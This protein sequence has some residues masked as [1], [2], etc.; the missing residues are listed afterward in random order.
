MTTAVKQAA[1]KRL[2]GL[3]RDLAGGMM[4]QMFFWGRDVVHPSGNLL[5]AQGFERHAAGGKSGTSCYRCRW[6]DGSIELL[7]AS[8]A[9]YPDGGGSGFI[10]IR[11]LG[12]CYRWLGN[13]PP[14]P[15]EWPVS[16]L[17][18]GDGRLVREQALPFIDWW[19]DSERRV[20][21][22]QGPGYRLNCYR[23]FKRLPRSRPWLPPVAACRWLRG[24]RDE[25]ESLPRAKRFSLHPAEAPDFPT[26]P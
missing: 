6:S 15:G 17:E 18:G 12:R 10:F 3:L 1:N 5:V 23:H 14:V 26:T 13:A 11:P 25:P 16:L 20:T 9:W 21:E 7:G 2:S 24:F 22:Q 19:L 4:Q 8:A